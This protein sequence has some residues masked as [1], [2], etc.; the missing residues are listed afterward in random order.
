MVENDKKLNCLCVSLE[1][2]FW[3]YFVFWNGF[4]VSVFKR[5]SEVSL[6]VGI[7]EVRS[8][9]SVNLGLPVIARFESKTVN[10]CSGFLKLPLHSTQWYGRQYFCA[11][12]I[13]MCQGHYSLSL[14]VWPTLLGRVMSITTEDSSI[15]RNTGC[16][17]RSL[18]KH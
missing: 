6:S 12:L 2:V 14:P 13:S 15:R 10:Q 3:F 4:T 1:E 9:Q 8:V 16:T 17:V 18:W 11:I 7:S 5:N